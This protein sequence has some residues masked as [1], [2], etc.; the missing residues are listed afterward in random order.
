MILLQIVRY[1]YFVLIVTFF[2][3]LSVFLIFDLLNVV[4]KT[5]ERFLGLVYFVFQ[6]RA[7]VPDL[8]EHLEFRAF[9]LLLGLL[10][11]VSADLLIKS[12]C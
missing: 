8:L 2:A 11:L 3:E 1:G 4:L 12:S 5:L 6:D 7:Q 10:D 9:H